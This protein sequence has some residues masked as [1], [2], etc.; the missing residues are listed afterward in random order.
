MAKQDTFESFAAIVELFSEDLKAGPVALPAK[1][2][3]KAPAESS[4]GSSVKDMLKA[5]NSEV[6]LFQNSHIKVGDKYLVCN[7]LLFCKA[8]LC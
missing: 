2:V 7:L 1:P 6:A 3:P 4:S 8:E 5:S